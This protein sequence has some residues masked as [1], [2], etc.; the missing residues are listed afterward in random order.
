MTVLN[1]VQI[2]AALADFGF[3]QQLLSERFPTHADAAVDFPT[4]NFNSEFAQC[5][6]P[7]H[8]VLVDG[9]DERAIEVEKDWRWR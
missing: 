3:A 7:G 6:R 1:F 9:I 2:N 8:H 4:W 5:G